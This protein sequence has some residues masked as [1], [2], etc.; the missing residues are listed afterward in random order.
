MEGSKRRFWSGWQSSLQL[1]HLATLVALVISLL[2]FYRSYIYVS[3]KLDVTVT[4]V[5]YGSN[6]G[7]L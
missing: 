3:Q 5:S 7:E 4:E 1:T 6:Q 2:S